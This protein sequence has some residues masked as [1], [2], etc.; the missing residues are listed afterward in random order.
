MGRWI[1]KSLRELAV[2]AIYAVMAIGLTYPLVTRLSDSLPGIGTDP[3]QHLWFAWWNGRSI[4]SSDLSPFHCPLIYYPTG[5]YM[6]SEP[7]PFGFMFGILGRFL[8]PILTFNLLY[9]SLYVFAAWGCY[10]LAL[11]IWKRKDVAFLGGLAFGFS[12]YMMARGTGH[13]NLLCT[14]FIPL[15]ILWCL[16]TLDAARFSIS[17]VLVAGI[18]I[19]LLGLSSN[20]Y[21]IFFALWLL[22]LCVFSFVRGRVKSVISRMA[23]VWGISMLVMSPQLIST[24]HAIRVGYYRGTPGLG[25]RPKDGA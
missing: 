1:Q 20:Y 22:G 14:G 11:Y 8:Q 2:L 15:A 7:M 5:G 3:Y 6:N 16:K 21:Y 17:R 4:L 23:S 10:R 18:L 25:H 24:W 19:G 12:T 9:L 13:I